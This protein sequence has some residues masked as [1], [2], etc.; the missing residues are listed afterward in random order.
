MQLGS[1]LGFK[2]EL[3]HVVFDMIHKAAILC[4]I[5]RLFQK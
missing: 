4:G 5:Q 2:I 1:L 3:Q